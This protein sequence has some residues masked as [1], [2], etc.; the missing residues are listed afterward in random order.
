MSKTKISMVVAL[1]AAVACNKSGGSGHAAA[2]KTED[3]KTFY[4]LG[5]LMG[6][7]VKVFDLKPAELALVEAGLEDAVKGNK[8]VVEVDAYEP[9]VGQMAHTRQTAHTEI[10]KGNAKVYLD[11]AAAEAGAEKLPS[12]MVIKKVSEG[13]GPMPSPT[14]TVKVHY[15]GRLTDG[16]VFDSS[17]QRGQPATFPLNGVVKCWTEGL[18]KMK[19]GGKALLTCPSDLAYGDMGRPPKIPGGAT[20]VFDVELLEIVAPPPAPPASTTPPGA[21]GHAGTMPG[22]PPAP[23]SAPA[24]HPAPSSKPAAGGAK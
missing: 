5:Q 9:K 6:R 8:A 23:G 2:P 19:V 15:E 4:T 20:L 14:D 11:K 24:G 16:T 22:H 13:T 3:E 10:E 7:G 18:S 21:P 1:L 12:G 17:K